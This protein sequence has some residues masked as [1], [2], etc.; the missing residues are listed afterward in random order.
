[1]SLWGLDPKY[2]L[3]VY[4]FCVSYFYRGTVSLYTYNELTFYLHMIEKEIFSPSECEVIVKT[5]A[6]H[7]F[8]LS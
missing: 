5:I 4:G 2:F 1:M 8:L 7:I 6:C 3:S